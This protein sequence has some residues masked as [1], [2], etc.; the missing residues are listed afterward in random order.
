MKK[1]EE[2]EI[3]FQKELE[4]AKR[5]CEQCAN[6]FEDN[7]IYFEYGYNSALQTKT[8]KVQ[9]AQKELT[10]AKRVFDMMIHHCECEKWSGNEGAP[11]G[12]PGC[13]VRSYLNSA[14]ATLSQAYQTD[15]GEGA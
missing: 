7:K 13:Y 5:C 14:L 4:R 9:I 11:N 3:A 12:C 2:L 1:A 10:E 8:D 6:G 15:E